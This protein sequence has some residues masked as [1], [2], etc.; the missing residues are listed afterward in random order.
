[1]PDIGYGV[2]LLVSDVAPATTPTNAIGTIM[3]FT[4]PSPTRDIID[5]TS[6]SSANMAREFVAGLIDYGES[7]FEM[8]WDTGSATDALLR[9]I[10]LE[11]APRTYRATFSQY[12]PARTITFLAYLTGYE[13]SAPMEDKM[14]ATVT[15]KVTGSPTFA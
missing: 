2:S 9:G 5:V 1:M 3:S 8:L 14:T 12:S 4:P 13:R 15:L 10:T 6:S 7:S 11:R